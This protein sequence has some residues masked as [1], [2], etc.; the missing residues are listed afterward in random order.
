[1]ARDASRGCKTKPMNLSRRKLL[2]DLASAVV[3]TGIPFRPAQPRPA[4]GW[5]FIVVGAGV[6]GAWI[7][8]N[9]QRRGH[10]VLLLDAWGAAHSRASSGG[11]TRVIRT[12]YAANS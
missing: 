7:A 5:D 4:G 2:R 9:L 6:F 1:M 11:E 8:W 10:R 3:L 12:E